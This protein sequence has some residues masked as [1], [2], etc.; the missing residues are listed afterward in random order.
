VDGLALG[1]SAELTWHVELG[2]YGLPY[3]L[4]LDA[5]RDRLSTV[6]PNNGRR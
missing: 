1:L 3:L 6:D 5:S 2:A 4:R